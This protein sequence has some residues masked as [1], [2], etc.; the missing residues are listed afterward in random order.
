M[1]FKKERK[2]E[3]VSFKTF[4]R[5]KIISSVPYFIYFLN[6]ILIFL[7]ISTNSKIFPICNFMFP[8]HKPMKNDF[9][10]VIIFH[11]KRASEYIQPASEIWQKWLIQSMTLFFLFSC[12]ESGLFELGTYTF[13]F[14]CLRMFQ[15]FLYNGLFH[16]YI[17][18]YTLCPRQLFLT[19]H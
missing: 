15:S 7:L 10:V 16:S 6:I 12:H 13:F 3:L 14:F 8:S 18:K 11:F 5:Y 2:L 17:N 19:S 1:F 4:S 9:L